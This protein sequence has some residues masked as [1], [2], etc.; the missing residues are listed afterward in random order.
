MAAAFDP[1]GRKVAAAFLLGWERDGRGHVESR[2]AVLVWDRTTGEELF[3]QITLDPMR[4]VAFAPDGTVVAGGGSQTGGL[5]NGWNVDTGERTFVLLGHTRPVLA[6][7]LGPS[8]RLATGGMDRT[9][10]VWDLANQ[11]EILTLEDFARE[12]V[13]VAFTKDGKNLVA[14]TGVDT[15]SRYLAIAPTDWPAAE[16]R[17]FRGPK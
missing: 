16:V 12:V 5:V 2:G 8:G 3:R 14:A 15:F 11:R 9:V 13:H 7:A 10:K 17:V 4:A 1:E 6:L